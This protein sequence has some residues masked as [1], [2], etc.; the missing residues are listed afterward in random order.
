MKLM[1]LAAATL[2]LAAG[3]ATGLADTREP[4]VKGSE[5]PAQTAPRVG[6]EVWARH[7]DFAT[8]SGNPGATVP[9][10][11]GA[12][13]FGHLPPPPLLPDMHDPVPLPAPGGDTGPA[14]A[15]NIAVESNGLNGLFHLSQIPEPSVMLMMLAGL[16]A[17]VFVIRRRAP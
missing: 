16:G 10:P 8:A 15:D 7:V 6:T 9:A 12:I 17:I 4:M 5:W 2:T 14:L 3:T 13:E 11:L 1:T